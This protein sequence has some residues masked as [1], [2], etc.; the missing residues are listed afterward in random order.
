[1]TRWRRKRWP[2]S[3]Q[4]WSSGITSSAEKFTLITDHAPLQ[5]MARAKDNECPGNSLVLGAPGLPLHRAPPGGDG[6]RQRRRTLADMGSFRRSVRVSP[7]PHPQSPPCLTGPGRR[8]GGGSVTRVPST[9][10]R[11]PGNGGESTCTQ[12]SRADRSQLKRLRRRL[13]KPPHSTH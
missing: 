8:L 9:Y 12:S 11:R 5:G 13:Q 7:H 2:S 4:S 6:Q 1:M 3:G 10:Q